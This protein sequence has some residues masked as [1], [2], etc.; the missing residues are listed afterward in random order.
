MRLFI[1]AI[2]IFA[3]L[4]VFVVTP[5]LGQEGPSENE[6]NNRRSV[7]D[8]IYEDQTIVYGEIGADGDIDD[9][10][11]MP[12][13]GISTTFTLMFNPEEVEID[14]EVIDNGLD[15]DYWDDR[16]SR[17]ISLTENGSPEAIAVE[18]F[19]GCTIHLWAYSGHGSYTLSIGESCQGPGEKEPNNTPGDANYVGYDW[20]D[21]YVCKDDHDWYA[22]DF[23]GDAYWDIEL[24]FVDDEVEIDWAIWDDDKLVANNTGYSSPETVSCYIA[25]KCW[26]HVW[27]FSGEGAYRLD[28]TGYEYSD[29]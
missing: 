1:S 19:G 3:L 14:W 7:A 17:T 27:Q 9:W 4:V 10:Y 26:L 16:E 18:T 24:S 28:L 5:L 2:T 29:Y 23:P 25:G 21:G 12:G 22:L 11:T 8:D 20:I 6:S 15:P 13:F